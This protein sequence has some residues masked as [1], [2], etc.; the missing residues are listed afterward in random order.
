[1][2]TQHHVPS[3]LG[4]MCHSKNELMMK[5]L[6]KNIVASLAFVGLLNS[7]CSLDLEPTD[8]ITD[9]KAYQTVE[10]L[11]KGMTGVMA[12]IGGHATIGMSDWAGDDLRYS[13]SNTG[14]GVQVHNW[15]YNAATN[16]LAGTWNGNAALVDRANR[17]LAIAE[18]FNPEDEVVMRVK[19]EALFARAYGHFEIVR[20]YC[21]NY[22]DDAIGIPYKFE[23]GVTYPSRLKQAEVYQYILADIEAALP[24]LNQYADRNYWITQSAAYALKA[25]VAQ[26]KGDWDRAIQ[27]ADDAIGN[28][29]F[30]LANRDEFQD[31]WNDEVEENVEVIFRLRRENAALGD[32]Y[33]RSSNGDVFFHPSYDLM[34]Q[35]T[36]DDIRYNSY[37]GQNNDGKDIVTKHDGR[38]DD[39]TNVVDLKVFR[40][41]EMVLIKAEAYANKDMLEA[42]KGEVN[43]L[44][45]KRIFNPVAVDMSTKTLAIKAVQAERRRELAYE[46]HRFYDLRRWGLGIDRNTEDAP[47]NTMQA[48]PAG[49][50]RFVFP[51]PQSEIFANPNMAQNK[52]YSN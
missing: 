8:Y 35:Y 52:G 51:I 42:A 39:K 45:S 29:H 38:I 50:Y 37:F 34:D 1:M 21:P 13:L 11:E 48:L 43:A 3:R 33:T 36:A 30:R 2:N 9:N 14:Q 7:A 23:S 22:A 20:L 31:V 24:N 27:A 49:D 40:V 47:G 15:T 12:S 44:R 19:A 5:K 28:G 46:G 6:T 16:D 26:Y 18:E 41:A 4:W 25:R 17:I 10:D 32:Y